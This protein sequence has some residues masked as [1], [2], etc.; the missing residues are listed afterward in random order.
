MQL[1]RKRGFGSKSDTLVGLSR[2]WKKGGQLPH[3]RDEIYDGLDMS[4]S[5]AREERV[6]KTVDRTPM[7]SEPSNGKEVGRRMKVSS[8]VS[9]LCCFK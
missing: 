6:R 3:C 7:G 8:L 9:S 2:A 4:H 1:L 5:D